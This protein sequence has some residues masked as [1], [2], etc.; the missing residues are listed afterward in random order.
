VIDGI[1][2]EPAGGA[3]TDHDEAA[4]LLGE[5]LQ[6]S[7]DDLESLAPDDLKRRRRAKFRSLGVYA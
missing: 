6:E 2:P 4:R 3:H 1:V 7:F 5:N